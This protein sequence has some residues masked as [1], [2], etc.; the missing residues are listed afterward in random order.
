ML[1]R[2]WRWRSTERLEG[3][4]E[5][6]RPARPEEGPSCPCDELGRDSDGDVKGVE[7]DS[8]ARFRWYDDGACEELDVRF[9]GGTVSVRT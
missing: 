8:L 9:S 4:R 2:G 1:V 6:G 7:G 3:C 5:L